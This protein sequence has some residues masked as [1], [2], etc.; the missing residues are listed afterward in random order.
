[1]KTQRCSDD[2]ELNQAR[3]KPDTVDQPVRTAC[4]FVHHYNSTQYCSTQTVLLTFPFLQTIITSHLW[5]SGAQGVHFIPDF[6]L[7]T[8]FSK[9]SNIKNIKIIKTL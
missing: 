6:I 5:T 3:P 8:H 2:R 9:N 4:G 7:L 1:M